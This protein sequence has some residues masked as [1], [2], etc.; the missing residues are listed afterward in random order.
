VQH[1]KASAVRAVECRATKGE[2]RVIIRRGYR[3]KMKNEK[4]G[5][6]SDQIRVIRETFAR[7]AP[8]KQSEHCHAR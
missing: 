5:L 3:G 1:D 4:L 8:Q 7:V 2:W 6:S